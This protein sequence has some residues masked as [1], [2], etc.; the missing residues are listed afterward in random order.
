MTAPATEMIA[1]GII[2]APLALIQP[3]P[4]ATARM[5][6]RIVSRIQ[7]VIARDVRRFRRSSFAAG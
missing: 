6:H 3:I 7:S 5:P 1:C 2:A 4:A